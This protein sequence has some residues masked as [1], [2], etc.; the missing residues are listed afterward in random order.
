MET[1][2]RETMERRPTGGKQMKRMIEDTK[3]FS[4]W[5]QQGTLSREDLESRRREREGNENTEKKDQQR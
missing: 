4:P 5:V 3:T 1:A 2:L